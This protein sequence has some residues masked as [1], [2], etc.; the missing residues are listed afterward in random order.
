MLLCNIFT[1]FC[2]KRLGRITLQC[3]MR[4]LR[5]RKVPCLIIQTNWFL[6]ISNFLDSGTG[7]PWFLDS[8]VGF[9]VKIDESRIRDKPVTHQKLA[10]PKLFGTLVWFRVRTVFFDEDCVFST[11]HYVEVVSV[12]SLATKQL[13][14]FQSKD[15]VM[16][17]HAEGVDGRKD[18]M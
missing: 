3:I 11:L 5:T 15:L 14:R 4:L 17:N 18:V 6:A 2:I 16:L 13:F 8:N 9:A 1:H 12:L 10:N 7:S